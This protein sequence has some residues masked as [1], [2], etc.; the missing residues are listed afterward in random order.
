M[1]RTGAVA[2]VVGSCVL[3]A[4]NPAQSADVDFSPFVGTEVALPNGLPACRLHRVLAPPGSNDG[5][6]IILACQRNGG[7]LTLV[8]FHSSR[9]TI[10]V[11]EGRRIISPLLSVPERETL[12]KIQ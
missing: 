9:F 8:P 3:G 6:I 11:E 10:A 12:A 5:Q 4:A 7:A 1:S 2:A